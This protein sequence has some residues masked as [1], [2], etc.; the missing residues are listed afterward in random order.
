MNASASALNC[1]ETNLDKVSL[2]C[3]EEAVIADEGAGNVRET[4]ITTVPMV[5]GMVILTTKPNIA[6]AMPRLALSKRLLGEGR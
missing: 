5:E 4:P 3:I 1:G 6:K 2:A